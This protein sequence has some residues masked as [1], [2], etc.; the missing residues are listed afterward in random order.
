MACHR[1]E[2]YTNFSCF[3]NR[4]GPRHARR[5]AIPAQ[6]QAMFP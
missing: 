6:K 4:G 1:G 3:H 5:V 2:P